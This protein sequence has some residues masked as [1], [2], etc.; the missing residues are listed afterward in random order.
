MNW[1]KASNN[2]KT[3]TV[4]NKYLNIKC[5]V[6]SC[7]N[8]NSTKYKS[9]TRQIQIIGNLMQRIVICYCGKGFIENINN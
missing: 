2:T 1:E 8:C 3:K 4:Y 9:T 5:Y 6:K 7:K